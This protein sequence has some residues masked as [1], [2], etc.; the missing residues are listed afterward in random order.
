M[1]GAG[2]WYLVAAGAAGAVRVAVTGLAAV[3]TAHVPVLART[4][5]TVAPHHVG[6][7]EAPPRL[8]IAGHVLPCSQHIAGAS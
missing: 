2:W 4:L 7:A 5:V 1:P 3:A 6:Q 8:V